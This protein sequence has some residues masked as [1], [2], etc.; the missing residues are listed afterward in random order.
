M[1]K[2]DAPPGASFF[3]VTEC[4]NCSL[5][6]RLNTAKPKMLYKSEIL[7]CVYEIMVP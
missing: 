7:D 1:T 6:Y 5:G 3:A 4:S 2:K